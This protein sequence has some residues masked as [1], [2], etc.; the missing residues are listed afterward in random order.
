[1]LGNM[2]PIPRFIIIAALIGGVVYGVS[3]S[4]ILKTM[5][6]PE[7][8]STQIVE[9]VQPVQQP[10]QIQSPTVQETQVSQ[11]APQT[12]NAGIEAL[13]KAGSKK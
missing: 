3:K 13:L 9:Q 2:K 5:K 4:G 8:Q 11:E 12:S 6:P 7:A 1:M 10:V